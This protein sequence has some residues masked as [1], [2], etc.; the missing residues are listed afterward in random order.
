MTSH[1][2]SGLREKHAEI[3]G[4]IIELEKEIASL[5]INLKSVEDTIKL[6]D[7]NFKLSEIRPKR[8][9]KKNNWF[10]RGE[11][12]RTIFLILRTEKEIAVSDLIARIME[13]KKIVGNH[14]AENTIRNSI[15]RMKGYNQIIIENKIVKLPN[16]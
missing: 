11:I 14:E 15:S 13:R 10:I 8:T 16:N 9:H 1:V 3:S 4:R 5:R 2:V 6:F 7:K 12:P